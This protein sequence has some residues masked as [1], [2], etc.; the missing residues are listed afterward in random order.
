MF[1]AKNLVLLFTLTSCSGLIS[2]H[3]LKNQKISNV[4][5]TSSNKA[6]EK[7]Q[8]YY[9]DEELYLSE[10]SK[11]KPKL[12]IE[13]KKVLVEDDRS[14]IEQD[15][16]SESSSI[17]KSS[18]NSDDDFILDYKKKHFDFWIKYYSKREKKRFTRHVN[19]GQVY[20]NVIDQILDYHE[21]PR[22]LFFV[23]LIESG[24]NTF[25]KS[26][27]SATGPWQFMSGTARDY[28]LKVN[29]S[30]DERSNIVKSTHAAAGYFKDLYNIFGSWELALCAYNAGPNRIIRA[31]KKGNTRDYKE[32]V[33]K[34][35]I[36]K[37]TIYYIPKAMAA[38]AIYKNPKKF[39]FKFTKTKKSAFEFVESVT[40]KGSFDTHKLASNYKVPHKLFRKLN[41]ELRKR[42]VK[43]RKMTVFIP[44]K[45]A[46]HFA[47]IFKK[48]ERIDYSRSS[49]NHTVY[50]VKRGDNLSTIARR[51]GVRLSTLKRI[52]NI[53]GS[54]IF[55]G[56]KL[57]IKK[58]HSSR[59][60]NTT[61]IVR[62]GENLSRIARKYRTSIR[63]LKRL[64]GLRSSKIM[65][66]QRLKVNSPVKYVRYKVKKGDNLY[67]LA[68]KF[69]LDIKEIKKVNGLKN[70]TLFIGQHLKIP[71]RG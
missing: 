34:R 39:G 11:V 65:V 15:L 12:V 5:A 22:D 33:K 67:L 16:R 40:V 20:K 71:N 24:Y 51:L 32:L 18:D 8:V 3:D 70:S 6:D 13:N 44:T 62:R 46:T 57:V 23:G 68:R 37:E 61:H 19:N 69:D 45:K 1:K 58:S 49:R 41:P 10:D 21:L 27:A 48:E 36:P 25:I 9:L 14:N 42:W 52:N 2:H 29:S 64:N 38:K 50:K 60:V 28:G 35:L 56:Q 66:G 26:R 47:G 31:I 53:R 30:V 4:D 43:N 7:S 17:S 54:K 55:V 63:S 59:R